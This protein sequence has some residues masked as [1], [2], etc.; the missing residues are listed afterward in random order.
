[1]FINKWID[2]ENM[3]LTHSGILLS[4]KKNEI[5]QFATTW[6]Y[7]EGIKLSEKSQTER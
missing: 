6:I 1:M 4:H 7:P 3:V 5:L 2:K